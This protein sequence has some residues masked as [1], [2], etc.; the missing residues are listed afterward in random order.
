[1]A[2]P[3][4]A[5]ISSMKGKERDL[6][7]AQLARPV[8]EYVVE[9]QSAV[10]PDR[11]KSGRRQP[12]L[13]ALRGFLLVWMTLTHLPTHASF[14]TNQP[15]GFVS[16]AEGFIFLSAM[17]T[18]RI[19]GRKLDELGPT[20]VCKQ[21]G[22]RVARLYGYH[23]V[24]LGVA[25]GAVATVAVHTNQPSLQGLVDFYLA[26]PL[27]AIVSSVLL[28]YRPPLLD[29]LPMYI[30]FL[31]L[32]PLALYM[33][34]RWGWKL[35]LIPSALIWLA[36]QFGLRMAAYNLTGSLTGFRIPFSAMGAFDLYG[37]QLL[38]VLGLW[39]GSNPSKRMQE[40]SQSRLV[41]AFA[42]LSAAVFLFIRQSHYWTDPNAGPW[43]PFTNKWQLGVL[44]L[45]NFAALGVLFA[46]SQKT[47]ARWSLIAP[48]VTLGKASLQVFCAHLLFCF[49][50]LALV[51]D[52]AGL[53]V[54]PQ[55]LIVVC[56]LLGLYL[57]AV[58]STRKQR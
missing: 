43:A 35:V 52:G 24:L 15:L 36:A 34:R 6:A 3:E 5:R 30:L 18:G 29:I 1:M 33:G 42:L 55:I 23:L 26:H 56:S 53:A 12:E 7:E 48:F 47:V 11:E 39:I 2:V 20:E 49:T 14:Y 9:P 44:R 4:F 31:A 45:G 16:A 27:R 21:L 51:G 13:D 32:T 41:I 38:W 17:L 8:E 19:F 40:L 37:W 46:A 58:V 50:A 28:I 22:A 25:F 10:V 57:V 54:W